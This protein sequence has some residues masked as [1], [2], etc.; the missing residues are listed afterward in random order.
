[1]VPHGTLAAA[2]DSLGIV[3]FDL[4]GSGF[5]AL[6]RMQATFTQWVPSGN[7]VLFDR[8]L[9]AYTEGSRH[10]GI[11]IVD[12]AGVVTSPDSARPDSIRDYEPQFS[13]DG[14]WIYFLAFDSAG[15]TWLRRM[16]A[17]GTGL[18]SID[19]ST[20]A[21]NFYFEFPAV[22][23]GD[24]LLTFD[25]GASIYTRRVGST[26]PRDSL[27]QGMSARWSPTAPQFAFLGYHGA[28]DGQLEVMALG[29]APRLIGSQ[30]EPYDPNP[31]WSPDGQYIVDRL[32]FGRI[33]VI[34]ATSGVNVPLPYTGALGFPTWRPSPP[35]PEPTRV[36]GR[37]SVRPR[38]RSLHR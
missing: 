24:S 6:T 9:Y 25:N 7:A 10:G 34:D 31:Q 33:E 35:G 38:R 15:N 18:A 14:A 23:A 5:H 3:V 12:T 13:Y 26:G 30:S 11:Y 21:A 29:G 2:S 37:S 17:D 1:M 28:D 36:R 32:F 19:S 22:S 20:P 8:S 4:D 27:T 16:H